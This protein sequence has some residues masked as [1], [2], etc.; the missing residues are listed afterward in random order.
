M[1]Y[2]LVVHSL[3]LYQCDLTFYG[4]SEPEGS[5]ILT[6]N[7][8]FGEFIILHIMTRDKCITHYVKYMLLAYVPLWGGEK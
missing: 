4:Y 2:I 6:Y 1:D 8:L 7:E 3:I 5:Y